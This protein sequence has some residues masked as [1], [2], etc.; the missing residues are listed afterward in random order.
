MADESKQISGIKSWA[1]D[2]R[3][4]EKMLLK[5]ASALSDAEL[6]AILIGSGNRNETA[7]DLAKR[8]L[9]SAS[10]N[11]NELGRVSLSD[12]QKFRGIGE[13]KAVSVVAAL[14]L[15]RRRKIAEVM[16]KQT[17]GSSSD[18]FDL[19]GN[20]LGDL[21]HEEFWVLYLNS[22]NKILDKVRIS[23]GGVTFTVTDVKLV[24]KPAIEKLASAIIVCHNHPSGNLNPSSQ[25]INL[26]AKLA[27]AG[28]ILDIRVHDHLIVTSGDY[29]SFK[30]NGLI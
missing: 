24:F 15:G 9:L 19:F 22:A 26:T 7:V 11:L 6:I 3:P 16:Q 17:I 5:G 25:D 1:E 2:D 29:F 13:A 8:I 20:L 12:L 10:Y 23:T 28:K 14:E 27:D 4:R 21:P 30:D 18:V